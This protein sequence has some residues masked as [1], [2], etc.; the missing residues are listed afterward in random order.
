M[1]ASQSNVHNADHHPLKV[2]IAGAGIAGLT[3]ALALRQQGHE[4]IVFEKSELVQ[5]FGA[6]IHLAPNCNGLLRRFGLKPEDVGANLMEG[7]YE[8]DYKGI[9]H[10]D[11]PTGGERA[12]MWQNPWQITHRVHLHNELKRMATGND[13]VGK[14]VVLHTSAKVIDIDPL[15]GSLT[16]ENGEVYFGDLVLGADGVGVN[17]FSL[18]IYSKYMLIF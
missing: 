14:P 4:C 7:F 13:G 1:S 11:V 2:L 3:A 10:M 6:A 5:E 17:I 16:L 18:H 12:K 15:K 8:V 9:V